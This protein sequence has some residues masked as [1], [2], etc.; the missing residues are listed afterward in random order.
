VKLCGFRRFD[1]GRVFRNQP[2]G[3]IIYENRCFAGIRKDFLYTLPFSLYAAVAVV[4][5]LAES[6]YRVAATVERFH[7]DLLV[8]RIVSKRSTL[9]IG[10]EV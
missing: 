9:C 5:I 7:L 4:K 1:Y 10:D 3:S 2:V 6:R 8:L